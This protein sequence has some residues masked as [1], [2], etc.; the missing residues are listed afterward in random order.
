ML[1]AHDGRVQSAAAAGERV[2]GG[3][4][5]FTGNA[6]LEVDERVE[7]GEGVGGGRVGGVVGGHVH[8]LHAVMAPFFVL[9]IRSCSSP[10][11][12]ASVG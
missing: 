1:L 6:A 3:V 12:V 9:V 7:V 2:D 11:S 4:D 10:I 8:G 5:A